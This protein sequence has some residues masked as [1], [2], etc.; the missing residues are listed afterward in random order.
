MAATVQHRTGFADLPAE[1]RSR[2]FY[3][4]VRKEPIIDP[5]LTITNFGEGY[6]FPARVLRTCKAFDAEAGS[7]LY[8][9]LTFRFTSADIAIRFIQLIGPSHSCMIRRIELRSPIIARDL[10]VNNHRLNAD[11]S[12]RP[13]LLNTLPTIADYIIRPCPSLR[14]LVLYSFDVNKGKEETR[15][16]LLSC[17]QD[18]M[19]SV[20]TNQL[21]EYFVKSFGVRGICVQAKREARKLGVSHE[22]LEASQLY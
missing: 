2:V 19:A 14:S 6:V 5:T 16:K 10:I 12:R 11:Y 20:S 3:Y 13:I 21:T 8:S 17:I 4:L 9:S 1:L 18:W 7:I 22:Y 15:S